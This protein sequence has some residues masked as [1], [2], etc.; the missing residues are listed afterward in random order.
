MRLTLDAL[1]VLDAIDRRGSFAAAAVELHR[2]PS[3]ITYQVHKLEDDVGVRVF[4]RRGHRARLTPAGRSLLAEGRGLLERA[5]ELERR[6]RRV[7]T[8]WEP[9][10]RIAV[11]ALVPWSLLW[12]V[13]AAFNA[14]CAAQHAPMTR[15]QLSREVLA[16]TWDALADGRADLAVG[17]TGDAPGPGYR[18]RPLGDVAMVFAVAPTHPLA[19]AREPLASRDILAHRAIVAADSSRHLPVRT[20]GLLDGQ[21]TLAVADL[22]AKI[23]AQVAG[24]GVGFVPVHLARAELA[25]GRL[26]QKR[27]QE[28]LASVR[29]VI[30][31]RAERGGKAQ[32]WWIDSLQRSPLGQALAADGLRDAHDAPFDGTAARRHGAGKRRAAP[33]KRGARKI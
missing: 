5:A 23:A 21:E 18:S 14:E 32:A 3:A 7:A 28:P 29:P 12:P 1:A 15:L 11:D 8:G 17:A 9:E 33:R 30:A 25:S 20:L 2:V 26:V 31:W 24:L 27:V 22:D 16:G 13:V 6:V 10:L 19:R 4:D